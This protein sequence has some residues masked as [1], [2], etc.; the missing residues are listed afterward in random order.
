MAKINVLD[1]QVAELIAAGEVVERPASIV[2]ELVEN[3]VDAGATKVT[4][5]IQGGGIRYIRVTDNGTGIA[6]EDV[7]NAFLRHATSKVKNEEDLTRIM[8]MGFRGEALASIAAMC[9][10][11]LLTRT[12]EEIAGTRYAISG[13]EPGE[14]SDAGCP[15]GTTIT[16]RDVF[17]N[18]PARMKFLKKDVSEGN[19]VAAAVEKAALGNPGVAFKF[20]RDGGVRLQTPGDGQVLSAVR[21]VLGREFSEN[22]VPV[23]YE[24]N[25][26][27][28]DG[29]ISRP[30][31]ARGSRGL[32][33]FFINTRFVRSKTCMAA[34]EESY[35]NTLMV[36]RYPSCV[37]NLTVPPQAV[38]VNVHPA[39]IEVRF[40]NEKSIFD[41]VYYGCKT[42]LG[43]NRLAPEIKAE[44]VKYNPFAANPDQAAPAQQRLSVGEYK[45]LLE[46][47]LK[48]ERSPSVLEYTYRPAPAAPVHAGADV[49][50]PSDYDAPLSVESP[51]PAVGTA[52]P[53]LTFPAEPVTLYF[54]K[55][56]V[57]E[58]AET[59]SL[60]IPE[61]GPAAPRDPYENARVIGEL[62]GTYV[63]LER[64]D[65]LVLVDKH[66]AHERL[67]F[68]RIVAGGVGEDRQMLLTPVSV[69]LSPEEHAA[70]LENASLLAGA[71][72]PVEDFGDGFVLVREVAPILADADIAGIVSEC[73][74]KLLRGG[75]KLLP[76]QLEDFYHTVA[77]RAAIKAHD[78]TP[79]PSLAELIEMLRQDGDA[80]HCP[81]GR[82]VS[83]RMR[84]HEIEKKFGRLG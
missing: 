8:T 15:T 49:P 46:K 55:E 6:R 35:R 74:D 65:E 50:P 47:R 2:K 72:I 77:C 31:F 45:E 81:H 26:L 21:C 52:P 56:P 4:V 62:F 63:L 57:P 11:E 34:L 12:A 10:V 36:G 41:L 75:G 60:G 83:V 84:R 1:K 3:A 64:G 54:D 59:A 66:A 73:A 69:K 70:V 30:S 68:N 76:R 18:T 53:A 58:T 40:A 20:L 14:L 67:L 79:A 32:Q 33:N 16:V 24:A 78:R 82:P 28:L 23:R 44:D 43:A 19:S 51:P 38:D 37:L 80:D 17:F 13:G 9:R 42:A 5:E 25:G 22:A 48:A 39:K 27:T 7:E 71:G 29:V 61:E